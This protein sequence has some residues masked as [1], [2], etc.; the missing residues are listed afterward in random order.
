MSASSEIPA[1]VPNDAPQSGRSVVPA[2]RPLYWS[3]RRE[4]WEHRSIYIAPLVAAG[5][6]MFGLL[7][8]AIRLAHHLSDLPHFDP[9]QDGGVLALPFGFAAIP[10]LATALIV[11]VFYCLGALNGERRDRS[12]LF[13]KSLPVSD[14]NAVLAKAAVPMLIL[15]IVA[16]A[17]VL[18]LHLAMLLLGTAV[19]AVHGLDPSPFWTGVPWL[20]VEVTLIYLV[21]ALTLWYAPIYGWLLMVSAWAK[22]APFL[23]AVLPPLALS[24]LE[25]IALDTSNIGSMLS[26]RIH[27][28]FTEAFDD[29]VVG[30]MHRLP[31]TGPMH[32]DLP[33]IDPAQFLATPGLWAGLVFAAAFIAAAVWLR[34]YREPT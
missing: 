26:Y 28:G 17:V 4:L 2:T 15:P 29:D 10:I 18:G 7:I 30:G 1:V 23:W 8:S 13:W 32:V 9:A 12:I 33:R 14:L 5:V 27:G 6:V 24:L 3:I 25:K 20:N 16:I 21:A 22:R 11:A 31:H 34:R 19:L